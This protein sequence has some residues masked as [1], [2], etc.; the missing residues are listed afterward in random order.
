MPERLE[1]TKN[2]HFYLPKTEISDEIIRSILEAASDNMESGGSYLIDEFREEK[3]VDDRELR[4]VYSIKVFPS[5]RPV[6][7]LNEQVE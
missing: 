7:F 2:A 5:V 3:V 4:Y 1:L 6:Y